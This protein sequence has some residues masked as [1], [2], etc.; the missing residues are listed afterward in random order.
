MSAIKVLIIGTITVLYACETEVDIIT[1]ETH[2]VPVV[3]S[4]IDPYDSI[5][6]VRIQRSFIIRDH[7]GAQLND[8]DSLYFSDVE[9]FLG[10]KTNKEIHWEFK[11]AQVEIKK[12]EGQFTGDNHH[13]YQLAKT[14]P[15]RINETFYGY[16]DPDVAMLYLKIIIHDINDT[17]YSESPVFSPGWIEKSPLGK[18]IGVYGRN[19][20]S[21]RIKANSIAPNSAF[22]YREIKFSIKISEFCSTEKKDKVV[23]WTTVRGFGGNGYYLTPE[24]LF[25][26]IM[27]GLQH[28]DSITARV[29]NGI[30]I[31]MT[32]ARRNY[33]DY[34][35]NL[36]PFEGMIDYPIQGI[37]NAYGF[38]HTK[39]SG[40][41]KDL[42]LDRMSMDSLCNSPKWKHLKFKHWQ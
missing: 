39:T 42:H 30:D 29:L 10:G 38:F 13:V 26:R 40:S 3:Y 9:V 20:T 41:L 22:N 37:E 31:E 1:P 12:Q 18:F 14:L 34:M 11:L 19:E 25:N 27:M 21:F 36:S 32:I 7:T 4:V 5:S 16:G 35:A 24:R 2:T 17:L 33:G 6:S 8:E 15:V 28:N 23:E